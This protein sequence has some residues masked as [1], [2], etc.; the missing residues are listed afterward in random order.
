MY[1]I[2]SIAWTSKVP[3]IMAHVH[4]ISGL[5]AIVSGTL[6]VQ[7]YGSLHYA[8]DCSCPSRKLRQAKFEFASVFEAGKAALVSAS[9][10]HGP[11]MYPKEWPVYPKWRVYEPSFL[12]LWRSRLQQPQPFLS[13]Q[14]AANDGRRLYTIWGLP[15]NVLN[16]GS[17]YSIV[18]KF[19][20]SEHQFRPTTIYFKGSIKATIFGN[21]PEVQVPGPPKS[22]K[23][24]TLY[25]L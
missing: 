14:K 22:P 16:S 17:D 18:C 6:E 4:S 8:S 3:K 24:R 20:I 11:P 10:L 12:V 13:P 5:K 15:L 7:E 1:S 21:D 9:P 23:S 2:F 19:P 25:C